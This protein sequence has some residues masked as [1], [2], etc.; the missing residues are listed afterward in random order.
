MKEVDEVTSYP[1]LW[2][3]YFF[4]VISIPFKVC[5]EL[6]CTTLLSVIMFCD[7]GF[8]FVNYLIL[9]FACV[10]KRKGSQME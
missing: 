6:L 9:S 5:V 10:S 8:L 7:E 2:N 3:Y 4:I 1:N